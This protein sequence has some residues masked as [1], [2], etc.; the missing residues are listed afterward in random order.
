MCLFLHIKAGGIWK[1][2]DASRTCGPLSWCVSVC[3]S[4]LLCP[5]QKRPLSWH[6][7]KPG[8]NGPMM[9]MHSNQ[10]GCVCVASEH[11][12]TSDTHFKNH[13]DISW[14]LR[15]CELYAWFG[16]IALLYHAGAIP[17][18]IF[19]KLYRVCKEC[20]LECDTNL[21]RSLL[22]SCCCAY[23]HTQAYLRSQ[24]PQDCEAVPWR[25]PPASYLGRWF[26]HQLERPRSD[27]RSCP[28]RGGERNLRGMGSCWM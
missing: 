1:P 27:P 21:L 18:H 15:R 16:W 13:S 23:T 14:H 11:G 4:C 26:E 6:A 5:D 24:R 12:W 20:S 17:K 10:G 28:E 22:C 25:S 7:V 3:R 2:A 9:L 8:A 19:R